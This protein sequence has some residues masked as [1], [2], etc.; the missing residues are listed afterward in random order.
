MIKTNEYKR[1]HDA[2]VIVYGDCWPV[3]SAIQALVKGNRSLGNY[4][5]AT[6]LPLL[7]KIIDDEPRAAIILCLRPREHLFLFYALRKR[8]RQHLTLVISDEFFFNDKMLLRWWGGIP[9][10]PLYDV[11]NMVD[12]YRRYEQAVDISEGVLNGIRSEFFKKMRMSDCLTELTESFYSEEQLISYLNILLYRECDRR[13]LNA[14]QMRLVDEICTNHHTLKEIKCITGFPYM[15]IWQAKVQVM[16]K[17]EIS[18][19]CHAF[20]L[21]IRFISSQQRTPFIIPP[22][23]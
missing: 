4:I 17:L 19:E 10:M 8:L 21:G 2:P 16:E 22:S 6:S 15:R 3:V 7:I 18:S 14:L 9:Y 13:R 1:Y 12:R 20:V 5:T 11:S 23:D